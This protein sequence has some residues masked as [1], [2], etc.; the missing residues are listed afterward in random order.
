MF[1]KYLL[2]SGRR[3]CRANQTALHMLMLLPQ[4]SALQQLLEAG[5]ALPQH[6]QQWEYKDS[7][8]HQQQRGE[9]SELRARQRRQRHSEVQ[10]SHWRLAARVR[11]GTG[12]RRG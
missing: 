2:S 1:C 10:L 3:A 4:P 11:C 8:F 5:P 9:D 7:S 12:S 6:L